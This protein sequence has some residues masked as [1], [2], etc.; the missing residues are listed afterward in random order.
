MNQ[1]NVVG[2]LAFVGFILWIIS[3]SLL[4]GYVFSVMWGWF[5]VEWLSAPIMPITVAIG[6]AFMI[7]IFTAK[8]KKSNEGVIT[9]MVFALVYPTLVLGFGWVVTWFM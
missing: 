5:I 2:I 9:Q 6:I 4:Q 1:D 7:A 3:A 8:M